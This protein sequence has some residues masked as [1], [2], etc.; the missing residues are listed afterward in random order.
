MQETNTASET[1]TPVCFGKEKMKLL[2][3]TLWDG[4]ITCAEFKQEIAYWALDDKL[5]GFDEIRP[6]LESSKPFELR[7]WELISD[8]KEKNKRKK[9]VFGL[10]AVKRYFA[11]IA[12][13]KQQNRDNLR[14]L[15]VILSYLPGGDTTTQEKATQ[16]IL[17]LKDFLRG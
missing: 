1:E 15:E 9:E 13:V 17:E 11:E 8:W 3:Q 6:K 16:R 7:E 5:G 4:K 14:W 12:F 2:L 10:P